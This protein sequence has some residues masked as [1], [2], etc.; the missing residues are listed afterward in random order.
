MMD[1][2]PPDFMAWEKVPAVSL[3]LSREIPSAVVVGYLPF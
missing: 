2:Y 1:I 3:S